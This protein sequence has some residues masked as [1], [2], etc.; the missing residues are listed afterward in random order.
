MSG[1]ETRYS[2]L[3]P[4][5]QLLIRGRAQ[6]VSLAV[7]QSGALVAPTQAGSTYTLSSNS[8]TVIVS[9]A[10]VTVASSVAYY[11][12]TAVQL[13][14]TLALGEGYQEV[15]SLVMPDGTTRSW[16]RPAALARYDLPMVL[17]DSHL[18][19]LYPNL[20]SERG[21]D[22]TSFQTQIDAAWDT[23]LR[24]LGSE[25][26]Y[27][28]LLAHSAP[29]FLEPHRHLTLHLIFRWF[30]ERTQ[31]ERYRDLYREHHALYEA[32]WTNLRPTGDWDHDG[33]VDDPEERRALSGIVH[34]GGAPSRWRLQTGRW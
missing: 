11:D 31:A 28:Y 25:G 10:A 2:P 9:A 18:E 34:R 15:W 6:R 19:A 20:S 27:P 26:A 16:V 22:Q 8:G 14:A 7:Y 12:L 5:P 33:K 23:L 4:Y 32:A 29:D 17:Q 1:Q 24:R 21:P 3:I 13:A 30:Y